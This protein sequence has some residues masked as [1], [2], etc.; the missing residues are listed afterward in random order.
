MGSVSPRGHEPSR[1]S[2]TPF[3][4]PIPPWG[5]REAREAVNEIERGRAKTLLDLDV[6]TRF[7]RAVCPY[8]DVNF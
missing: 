3:L 8:F 1:E 6:K 7:F 2:D 5:F 4:G